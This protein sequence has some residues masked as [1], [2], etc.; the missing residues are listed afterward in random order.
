M[1]QLRSI[2]KSLGKKFTTQKALR[3]KLHSISKIALKEGEYIEK[4]ESSSKDIALDIHLLASD[5][6]D[7]VKSSIKKIANIKSS[8][9]DGNSMS[10]RIGL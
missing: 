9:M 6:E 7:A 1:I 8:Q 4:L 10:I 3:D 2:K 5:R